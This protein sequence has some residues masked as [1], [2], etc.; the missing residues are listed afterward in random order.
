MT[1]HTI[2]PVARVSSNSVRTV[3]YRSFDGGELLCG[4]LFIPLFPK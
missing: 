4:D 3:N 2:V 1:I